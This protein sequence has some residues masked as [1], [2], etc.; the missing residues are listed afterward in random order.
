MDQTE[1]NLTSFDDPALKGGIRRTW[2]AE[3]APDALRARVM[4]LTGQNPDEQPAKHASAPAVIASIRPSVWRHPWTR[5]G[6]AA[7]AMVVVGF[8]LASSLDNRPVGGVG[9]GTPVT[10][11]SALPGPIA[12]GLVDSHDRCTT[13]PDHHAYPELSPGNYEAIRRRL[14]DNLGFPVIAGPIEEALG[15]GGWRFRGAAVCTVGDVRAAHLVFVRN[16]QAISVFSLPRSCCK[17]PGAESQE[18]EDANP[19]HPIALF[20]W[21]NGVHC[22]VGSSEDRSLSVD[23]VRAVLEHLRPTVAG[24]APAPR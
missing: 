6:M 24:N 11:A 16:G 19:D 1:P 20:V 13:F 14:Q 5:Y 15:R 3:R 21:S 18:C 7:A 23:E 10:M 17:S 9:R 2:G 12:K 8:G 22:V 4:A